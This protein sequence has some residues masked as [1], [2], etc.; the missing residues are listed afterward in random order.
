MTFDPETLE[1]R[2]KARKTWTRAWFL[3][4]TSTKQ[5]GPAVGP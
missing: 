1:S 5:I 3:I 4:K 2:S